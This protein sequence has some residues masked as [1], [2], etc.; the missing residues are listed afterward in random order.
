MIWLNPWLLLALAGL[1]VVWWLMRMVPPPP[2]RERFPPLELLRQLV[3]SQETPART[4][5]W[6]LVLRC[7][8]V[9]L[10]IIALAHPVV[11]A[12]RGLLGCETVLLVVDDGWAA[13]NHWQELTAV[14]HEVV[15]D[16][17]RYA[18][19]LYILTT[20]PSPTEE[21]VVDGPLS[22]RLA[23]ELLQQWQPKS[24]P[25]DRLA[26]AN[27]LAISAGGNLGHSNDPICTT[28]LSDGLDGEGTAELAEQMNRLGSLE[29]RVP[30]Q[31]PL[32]LLPP[33]RQEHQIRL[34]VVR[35]D[36][37]PSVKVHLFGNQEQILASSQIG[38]EPQVR[39]GSVLLTPPTSSGQIVRIQIEQHA[40]AG[41]VVLLDKRWQQRS[42]GLVG[43]DRDS[44][45]HPLL[46]ELFYL[47]QAL[48][49]FSTVHQGTVDQLLSLPVL[50]LS[51]TTGK[52]EPEHIDRLSQWLENGGMLIRLAG[53]EIIQ[54]P[55]TLLPV[56]L[57]HRE[58]TL[59][60]AL[61]W[62]QPAKFQEFAADSPF[63]GLPVPDEVRVTRQALARQTGD[64]QVWARLEDGTPVV[65]A[66]RQGK[67]WLVLIHTNTEW[68]NL[69]LSELFVGMLLRLV[70][71]G[72]G[73]QGANPTELLLP[74]A[75]LDGFGK[76]GK[77]SPH[78]LAIQGHQLGSQQVDPWHPPGFYAPERLD[79]TR[80]A[81]NLTDQLTELTPLD[82]PDGVQP[83]SYALDESLDLKPWL[84]NILWL[85]LLLD[86][87][88][89]LFLRG[90]LPRAERLRGILLARTKTFEPRTS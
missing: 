12:D 74:V 83:R 5:W 75:Q 44:P 81:L 64:H 13:A 61:S 3:S 9:A 6:L 63:A 50:V 15:A 36:N 37:H 72:E 90:F 10:L 48:K 20:A 7:L 33:R 32:L 88:V 26:A 51:D 38:F 25:V 40:S 18:I 45:A 89:S 55:D 56:P 78:A 58:R 70:E 19:P 85:L 34:S 41:A 82:L 57:Q 60:G 49:L 46:D 8:A 68:S 21:F 24:W 16:S 84:L 76:L 11:R 59:D 52:L 1:P 23:R 27:A 65:T 2:R 62:S 22:L 73:I 30:E 86:L 42:V 77:P 71:R 4:S 53:P 14:A 69:A 67:G 39:S 66:L 35:A 79:G 87:L 17:D 47:R 28:W 31:L 43:S 54:N 80:Y 29:V